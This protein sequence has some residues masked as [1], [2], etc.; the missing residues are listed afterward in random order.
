MRKKMKASECPDLSHVNINHVC[1]N[2]D[3]ATL[4]QANINH[5]NVAIN[6]SSGN[7][8]NQ[9]ETYH[10][11]KETEAKIEQSLYDSRDIYNL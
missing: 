6:L 7:E 10:E 8:L 4:P 9:D 3:W 11:S 1:L 5:F 2:P